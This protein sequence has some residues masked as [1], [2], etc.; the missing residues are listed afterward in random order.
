MVTSSLR[1]LGGRVASTLLLALA[2]PS[3]AWA[4][5]SSDSQCPY[6]KVC[7]NGICADATLPYCSD[8]CNITKPCNTPCLLG[9]TSRTCGYVN[10]CYV[11]PCSSLCTASSSCSTSC[12]MD[13]FRSTCSLHGLCYD[14]ST[15]PCAI[16]KCAFDSCRKPPFGVNNDGDGVPDRLEYDLAYRYFPTIW[17]QTL[18][19][20]LSQIYPYENRPIPYRVHAITSPTLCAEAFKCLEIRFGTAYYLDTGDPTLGFGHLGDPEFYFA[21][22]MRTSPWSQASGT[23]ADWQLIR[24]FTSAHFDT[25]AESSVLG[26]YGDCPPSCAYASEASCT[27]NPRC[28]WFPGF[29][30]GTRDGSNGSCSAHYEDEMCEGS[31]GDCFWISPDCSPRG[32]CYAASPVAGPRTIYAAEGKHANYHSDAECDNGNWIPGVGE[33]DE[34]P[35]NAYNWRSYINGRLQNVGEGA[36]SEPFDHSIQ[37]PAKCLLYDVWGDAPFGDSARYKERF[38]SPWGWDLP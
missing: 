6:P 34:C 12:E 18:A 32:A 15:A 33:I 38:A 29:C 16:D 1:L 10:N 24:D 20:D 5:C 9:G 30:M 17:L 3:G 25:F 14:P 26:E 7:R 19:H 35:H 11:A 4:F 2:L 21:V 23:A 36:A 22:V 28:S 8:I 37:H 27:A 13:G 31:G